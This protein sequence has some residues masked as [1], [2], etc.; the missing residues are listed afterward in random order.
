[1]APIYRSLPPPTRAFLRVATATALATTLADLPAGR[2][3]VAIAGRQRARLRALYG[4]VEL[5]AAV[6]FS[7]P[8]TNAG[9]HLAVVRALGPVFLDPT[10][11]QAEARS[12]PV[13]WP[14]LEGHDIPRGA[15]RR[16]RRRHEAY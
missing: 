12:L 14:L 9:V 7:A 13:E 2:D 1:M 6:D 15:V 8:K 4:V 3:R 11:L 5:L 16:K 10:F